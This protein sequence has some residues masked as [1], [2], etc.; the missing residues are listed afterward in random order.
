LDW[1]LVL[2]E[3]IIA[4]GG[5]AV[6][7]LDV[8]LGGSGR[9]SAG[10][11]S[12]AVLAAALAGT[13]RLAAAA[14][15]LAEAGPLW[16]GMLVGDQFAVLMKVLFVAVGL[17]V[18]MLSV[19]FVERRGLPAGEFYALVLF[20]VLGM[21]LM[22]GSRD[23]I[24][25]YLGLETT[26]IASYVLAGLLRHDPRSGEAAIKYFLTGALAS[27]VIL[28]GFSFL[29]GATGSTSL[30]ALLAGAGGV[31]ATGSGVG[32]AWG[33]LS[34]LAVVG[35]VLLVAGFGFK[36]A[37]VPFHFW[38]PDAYEGAPTPVTAFFSVGPKAA[39]FAVIL[40][41]FAPALPWA[42]AGAG[43][44]LLPV[45]F[46]ALAVVTMTVGNLVALTQTNIKRMLAY[47]SIAHAGY[48]LVGLAV[49][50]PRGVAAV[51]YYLIAYAAMN[52]GAF[53][54]V[55]WLNNRGTGDDIEDYVGLSRRA[56]LAAVALVVCFLSLI[57]IPPMAGFFGKFYLFMAAVEA[58][59]VWLAVVMVVNSAISVGYYY[60]IVRNMYL[61]SAEGAVA[62]GA[63]P[64]AGG[65]SQSTPAAGEAPE[66]P[67]PATPLVG[68]ALAL[69]VT[70]VLAVGFL[71]EPLAR[72]A[73]LAVGGF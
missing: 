9:R 67:V 57:G 70:A 48:I 72:L 5:L 52:L 60:A 38:A 43:L 26:A 62:D 35:L 39:A 51:I 22:A 30:Q 65:A 17:L 73:G 69:A 58:D 63:G 29:F 14:G 21:M 6:L 36:V 54:V 34:P 61:R 27:A 59:M 18:V 10:Y 71:F 56:P 28:F 66:K 55:I 68:T 31:A 8:F 20:A 64:A 2:P 4:G 49:A 41:V 15:D 11:L 13:L 1:N 46:A 42:G 37:A 3:L 24:M 32:A 50:T 40:R 23:L 45:L 53:A 19:D 33:M 25:I 16:Q 12:L 47:S 7:L 44:G